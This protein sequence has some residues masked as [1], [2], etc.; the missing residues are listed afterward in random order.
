MTEREWTEE[1]I[2]Y[3]AQCMVEHDQREREQPGPPTRPDLPDRLAEKV[4]RRVVEHEALL[5]SLRGYAVHEIAA[6]QRVSTKTVQRRVD[7][8]L[9]RSVPTEEV[10]ALRTRQLAEATLLL[11]RAIR[12]ATDDTRGFELGPHSAAS[13]HMARIAALA[14][15]D[16]PAKVE[17]SRPDGELDQEIE[18]LMA[19][20]TRPVPPAPP[21]HRA[22][23][24]MPVDQVADT[25][26]EQPAPPR[27]RNGRRPSGPGRATVV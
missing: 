19:Q 16:Q 24:P 7:R 20:L 12:A 10:R 27:E 2:D 3:L 13:R 23:P 6:W 11:G 15:L 22:P 25:D 5:L 4:R 9:A 14:G 26:P 8:A 18:G 1:E 21:E 17:L